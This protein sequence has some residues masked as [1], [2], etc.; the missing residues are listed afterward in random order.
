MKKITGYFI[1][2]LL[3]LTPVIVTLYVFYFFFNKVEGVAGFKVP[4]MG[5]LVAF[6]GVTFVG[7]IAS[8][9]ITSRLAKLID[10][11]FVRLPV[12]KMVYTSIKDL[13]NAFVG[14]KKSFNRPVLVSLSGEDKVR[15]IGFLTCDDLE[16]LAI[17]ESVAVYLPQSYNFAGNLIVVSPAQV[18]PLDADPGQVMKFVVSGGV[19]KAGKKS[20]NKEQGARMR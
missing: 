8:N 4:G 7:F 3:F 19:S 16:S 20:G 15:A 10:G 2:G 5:L 18:T 1:Q 12:V 14:D 9:F 6:V 13:V 17:A 11:L